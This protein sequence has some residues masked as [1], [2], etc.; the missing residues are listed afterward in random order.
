[1][2]VAGIIFSNL[3]DSSIPELTRRRT[4]ASIPFGCRYRLI[5]FPLSN[6]V[7]S[8]ISNIC[9]IAHTNYQSLMDHIGSGKDW[10]LARRSGGIRLLPPFMNAAG[11]L[12]GSQLYSTRMEAM[13]SVQS[14]LSEI[15]EDY[16]ILSDCDVIC[17]IDLNDLLKDHIAHG[18]D[19]TIAVKRVKVE[20]MG[21][22]NIYLK[23]DADGNLTDILTHSKLKT[24]A[25]DLN[26]NIWVINREYLIH[27]LENAAAHG[28]RS[29]TQDILR[30]NLKND[31]FR[32]YCYDGYFADI[33]S[34]EEYYARSMDLLK[35]PAARVSLFGNAERPIFTQRRN[36]SPTQHGST[37]RVRNSLIADD[38]MIEGT[39]ENSLIFR[40][41]HIAR[42]AIVR[43][44]ILMADT[45]VGAGARLNCVITDM[46]VSIRDGIELS[47]HETLPFYLD[48]GRHL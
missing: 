15:K 16:V 41:V 24:R 29:F 3:H 45:Y 6:M 18:A 7:N 21:E 46:N 23:S 42:G 9:V 4:M 10:D 47:G 26:L 20:E 39:V 8:G 32:V 25:A 44:S 1:M 36:S 11:N 2:S 14:S 35:D 37:A 28:Y 40:G 13:L 38:C 33:S 48:K 43:N 22:R 27:A 17:N 31:K 19:I 34:L 12:I 5:D 30:R